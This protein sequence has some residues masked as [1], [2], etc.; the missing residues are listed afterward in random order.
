MR[1]LNHDWHVMIALRHLHVPEFFEELEQAWW[2]NPPYIPLADIIRTRD[3]LEELPSCSELISFIHDH[4]QSLD[5][6]SSI[7]TID[8]YSDEDGVGFIFRDKSGASCTLIRCKRA[9]SNTD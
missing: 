5:L 3:H 6:V 2:L 1:R 9:A 7:K 8:H 4:C